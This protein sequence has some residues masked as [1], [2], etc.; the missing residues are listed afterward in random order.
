MIDFKAPDW[1]RH[2]LNYR[3]KHPIHYKRMD[4]EGNELLHAAELDFESLEHPLYHLLQSSG[5]IY[6]FPLNYPFKPEPGRMSLKNKTFLTLIDIVLYCVL[7]VVEEKLAISSYEQKVEKAGELLRTYYLGIYDHLPNASESSI[8][9][10]L[11]NRVSFK[12]NFFD[13]R[14]SGIN[15]HFFWDWYFFM[16]FLDEQIQG[17]TIDQSYFSDLLKE[18]NKMNVLT[19]KLITAAIH[20]NHKISHGEKLLQHHFKKSSTLLN[21]VDKARLNRLLKQGITLDTIGLPPLDWIARR[22]LLDVCLLAIYADKKIDA[23]EEHF[24]KELQGELSLPSETLLESKFFL[25]FF[26]MQYGRR[27][28]F[29]RRRRHSFTLLRM[30]MAEN[31]VKMGKATKMEYRETVEMAATLGRLLKTQ[32]KLTEN[33]EIPSEEEIAYALEQLKDLP[34]FLPF[35]SLVFVPVPGITEAYILL[36]YSIEKLSGNAIRLLPSN[37]SQ[38]VKKK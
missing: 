10:I 25:G 9:S 28:H 31:A 11:L 20:S 32:L 33:P 29:Y 14:K 4:A 36:A 23:D 24:L 8:D 19:L 12:K 22:Y 2:Y 16:K 18:K 21:A 3:K 30:A 17:A 34:K 35:F 7:E 6:G 1:F 5:V 15:S 27:L 37:F 38:M 13:F 26:L